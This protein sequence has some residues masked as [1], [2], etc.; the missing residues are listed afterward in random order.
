MECIH[1]GQ[2]ALQVQPIEQ[3]LTRRDLIALVG[4]RFDPQGPSATRIDGSD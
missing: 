4:H 2:R 3:G 1:Q